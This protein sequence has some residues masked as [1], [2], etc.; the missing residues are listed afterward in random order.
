MNDFKQIMA[1]IQSAKNL[2][3]VLDSVKLG[4]QHLVLGAQ[5]FSEQME[6]AGGDSLSGEEKK[7]LVVRSAQ[8]TFT[9]IINKFFNLPFLSEEA[10]AKI[11]DRGIE[12]FVSKS[13]DKAVVILKKNGWTIG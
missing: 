1:Q 11:I 5:K 2:K 9:P 13:I 4:F 10:E 6:A 12:M 8:E 3:E 7:A